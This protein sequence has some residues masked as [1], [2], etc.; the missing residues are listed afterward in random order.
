MIFAASPCLP[1]SQSVGLRHS[2]WTFNL[3]WST[4]LSR[5]HALFPNLPGAF[6]LSWLTC[7]R[8]PQALSRPVS[9]A[10]NFSQLHS[11]V[12][13]AFILWFLSAN[14]D[15]LSWSIRE[16]KK[17]CMGRGM[18]QCQPSP[19]PILSDTPWERTDKQ[20]SAQWC[21]WTSIF[22]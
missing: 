18:S 17:E 7:Y 21:W 11:Q 16:G 9:N 22:W 2:P 13:Q 14:K 8:F 10:W 5:P 19:G 1:A 3:L 6:W 12:Y 20:S 15:E 4:R